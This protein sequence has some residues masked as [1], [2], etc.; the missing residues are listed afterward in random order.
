VK[1]RQVILARSI[2]QV[3]IASGG[4]PQIDAIAQI[5]QKYEFLKAPEK[6][7]ELRPSPV[8]A[9]MAGLAF[10]EG[11]FQ[12][13]SRSIGISSLQF[14]PNLL[15]LDT[16]SSTEDSDVILDDYLA[17]VAKRGSGSV[18]PLGPS[19]YVSQLEFTMERVPGILPQFEKAGRT[20]DRC[21]R[22]YG[23]NL[24]EY[25]FWSVALN[26]DQ[27]GLA[28]LQPAY[29]SLERRAGFPFKENMFFSQAPL[30]TKDHIALLEQFD[31][32]LH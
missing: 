11:K 6:I 18:I 23:L 16:R 20:V 1:L 21:L 29:F 13:G 26:V 32:P 28:Q 17:H 12:I 15:I 22:D 3:S 27:H 5:K 9:Q 10:L 2:R 4:A 8:Q 31:S 14:L 25:G 7:E 30:Q 19:Y 24:P